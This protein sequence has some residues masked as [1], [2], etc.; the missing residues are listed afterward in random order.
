M[1]TGTAVYNRTDPP[2]VDKNYG[3]VWGPD[4]KCKRKGCRQSRDAVMRR[5]RMCKGHGLRQG[6]QP[7]REKRK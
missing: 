1:A 6:P 7:K 4:L 3:H 5:Q 2:K